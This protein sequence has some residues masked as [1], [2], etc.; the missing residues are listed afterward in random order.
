MQAVS[1]EE[2]ANGRVFTETVDLRT[3]RVLSGLPQKRGLAGAI[4]GIAAAFV[5]VIGLLYLTPF[6]SVS[7]GASTGA[8]EIIGEMQE[9][10]GNPFSDGVFVGSTEPGGTQDYYGKPSTT[11]AVADETTGEGA[12]DT[13]DFAIAS[14]ALAAVAAAGVVLTSQKKRK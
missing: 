3:G 10:A 13:A 2:D 14:V 1:S 5:L 8:Q 12:A 9:T 11:E 6:L 4:G 7:S